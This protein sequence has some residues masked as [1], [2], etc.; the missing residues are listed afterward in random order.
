MITFLNVGHINFGNIILGML[1]LLV[2]Y[3][4]AAWLFSYI[5]FRIANHYL[6]WPRRTVAFTLLGTIAASI[7]LWFAYDVDDGFYKNGPTVMLGIAFIAFAYL[8]TPRKK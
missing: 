6:P 3:L 2:L 1:L 8:I 4:T 5:V 7:L